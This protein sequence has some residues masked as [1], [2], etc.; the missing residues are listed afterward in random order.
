ME[1]NVLVEKRVVKQLNELDTNTRNRVIL[2]LNELRKGFSARLDVK[3]MKGYRNHYRIRVGEYRILFETRQSKTIV[4]Y[5]I[6]PR[7]KAY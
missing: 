5:A 1:F 7:G 6:L 2:A 4:V 3:K